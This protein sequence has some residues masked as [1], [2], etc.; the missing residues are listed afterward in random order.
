MPGV[1]VAVAVAEGDAVETGDL[2]LTLESMKLE[3][4]ITAPHAAV[5]AEICVAAGATFDQ[6][7]ALLRLESGA[8]EASKQ[9]ENPSAKEKSPS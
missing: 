9:T 3:T 5:V 6:G 2:L 1:V 8:G 4:A 7:A